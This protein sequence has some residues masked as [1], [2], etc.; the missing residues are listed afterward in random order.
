MDAQEWVLKLRLDAAKEAQGRSRL[1]LLAATFFSIA[2]VITEWNMCFSWDRSFAGYHEYAKSEVTK[3]L[4]K[5]VLSDWVKRQTISFAL[6]GIQVGSDDLPIL[7]PLTLSV[8]SVWGLFCMRRQ[9]TTTVLL[10]EDTMHDPEDIRWVVYHGIASYNVFLNLDEEALHS[11]K[12]QTG[13]ASRIRFPFRFSYLALLFFPLIAVMLTLTFDFIEVH[14]LPAVFRDPD[15]KL[16][17]LLGPSN[18]YFLN[19]EYFMDIFLIGITLFLCLQALSISKATEGV[20]RLYR[21]AL[22]SK[23]GSPGART[24]G[25]STAGGDMGEPG[26]SSANA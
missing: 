17:P 20:L 7:G 5:A 9:Y 15:M 6:L 14:Y 3:D 26:P 18:R 24:S 23:P 25:P 13:W 4:Q 2:M 10:L 21:Q 11:L 19:V 22:T 16:P 8:I 12:G 1:A